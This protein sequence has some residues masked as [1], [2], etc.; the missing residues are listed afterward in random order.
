MKKYIIIAILLVAAFILTPRQCSST[1]T[2]NVAVEPIQTSTPATPPQAEAVSPPT[3]PY[4]LP[5]G[6]T[7]YEKEIRPDSSFTYWFKPVDE[8]NVTE[9]F[10]IKE[11][12]VGFNADEVMIVE[13]ERPDRTWVTFK[14]QPKGNKVFNELPDGKFSATPMKVSEFIDIA[15]TSFTVRFKPY[16]GKPMKGLKVS[17]VK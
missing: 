2:Q 5:K 17:R 8:S 4:I 9:P 7:Y 12:K 16:E 13:F 15:K 14:T 3:E 10:D 6:W 11:Y 1:A